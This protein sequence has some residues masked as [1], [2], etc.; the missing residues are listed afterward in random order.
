MF[1]LLMQ[2]ISCTNKIRRRYFNYMPI[3]YPMLAIVCLLTGP[4]PLR[5]NSA[6]ILE[7]LQLIHIYPY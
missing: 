2:E 1:Q 3:A 5:N 6:A 7:S 4:G